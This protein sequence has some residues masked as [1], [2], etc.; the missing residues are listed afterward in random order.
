MVAKEINRD[1]NIVRSYLKC[2][3]SDNEIIK[4]ADIKFGKYESYIQELQDENNQ[5][6]EQLNLFRTQHKQDFLTIATKIKSEELYQLQKNK[7]RELELKI[8]KLK[9]G[10]QELIHKIALLNKERLGI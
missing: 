10:N 6:K 1:L 9:E 7:I 8:K 5:L 4:Q 2:H 3:P